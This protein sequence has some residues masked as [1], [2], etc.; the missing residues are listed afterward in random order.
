MPVAVAVDHRDDPVDE[1]AE[2]V[3]ELV[4][5]PA[6]QPADSEVG[7]RAPGHLAQ[8][9]PAHRVRAVPGD[10]V[11][12]VD[13]AG[14]AGAAAGLADLAAVVGEVAVDDD[15]GRD[16][17]PGRQQHRRPVDGVEPEHPLAKQ[18]DAPRRAAPPAVEVRAAAGVIKC[19]EVVAERI[20]P[21]VDDLPRVAGDGD[22]PAAGA[23][24]A[25]GDREV[26]EPAV[27]EREDLV[28]ALGR[29]D[30]DRAVGDEP[31][32]LAGVAG[33]AEEPVH[34]RHRLGQRAVLGAAAAGQL[35]VGVKLLAADAV[36]A[37]VMPAVQVAAGGAGLP[38][39]L[40]T[41]PVPRVAARADQVVDA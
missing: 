6:D 9:P 23:F 40:N 13:G 26:R 5:G 28:A 25:A 20:P 36:Q 22:A 14:Q 33:Q 24:G 17:L 4:V 19:R 37:L 41:R 35:R 39:P 2:A 34:F 12:R 11:V 10:E 31:A 16:G 8:Q 1:V 27:D 21:H 38:Q 18:V 15:V 32:Q 30:A 7:V 3:G 29:L